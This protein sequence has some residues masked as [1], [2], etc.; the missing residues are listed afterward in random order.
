MKIT[1]L[2]ERIQP[3]VVGV[4][5][6][7]ELIWEGQAMP[8]WQMEM[9]KKRYEGDHAAKWYWLIL[10]QNGIDHIGESND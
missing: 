10:A 9:F 7:G 1:T 3:T 2:C 6:K 8:R 4:D 5:G